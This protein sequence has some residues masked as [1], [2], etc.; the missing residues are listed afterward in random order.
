MRKTLVSITMVCY[1]A[2]T[3]G[4][5]VNFHYCMD[6]LASTKLFATET[7]FCN[8]C[9]MHNKK[10]GCCH[11]DI[12]VIKVQDA[13][14]QSACITAFQFPDAGNM[15]HSSFN[16]LQRYGVQRSGRWQN[17]SPPLSPDEQAYLLNCNF[18]I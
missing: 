16:F 1:L 18:R 9:G 5:V 8:K 7:R 2:V 6:R 11:D 13:Q 14:Q 15:V 3:S 12:K 17:H 4:V 10:N